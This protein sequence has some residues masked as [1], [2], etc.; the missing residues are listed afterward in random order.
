MSV[1]RL[2]STCNH[3]AALLFKVDYAWQQGL[4]QGCSKPCT[5]GQNIWIKP[6]LTDIK[7][8]RAADMVIQKPILRTIRKHSSSIQESTAARRLFN[9]GCSRADAIP[10]TM[11]E[12]TNA[13]Y[14]ACN[15]GVAF[16]YSCPD[17][18]VQFDPCSDVNV[19]GTV[20]CVAAE[21]PA[22]PPLSLVAYGKSVHSVTDFQ[23]PVYSAS[24][25]EQIE[26]AA[27]GQS[28]N[29]LWYDVRC[30][31]KKQPPKNN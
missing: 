20:D 27:R 5:A 14:P 28:A 18:T 31:I 8:M 7:P 19:S 4:T 29:K 22:L 10:L 3:V 6:R 25:I 30:G 15:E 16:H 2:G 12:L 23:L 9:T 21:S 17:A 11:A 1:C 24:A 13:V 26:I